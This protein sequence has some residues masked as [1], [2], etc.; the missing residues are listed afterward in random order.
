MT[1]LRP[2]FSLL[3]LIILIIAAYLVWSWYQ[4]HL[5]Q[6]PDGSFELRRDDWRLWL[7][8]LLMFWSFLGR[9]AVLPLLARTSAG[10]LAAEDQGGDFVPGASGEMLYVRSFGPADAPAI[11]LTHGWSLDQSVWQYAVRDLSQNYR[12]IV[13]DLPG[14]GKSTAKEVS[15][16]CM[17]D[18]LHAVMAY[19]ARPALLVGHSIG[20][21]TIQTLLRNHPELQA[22]IPGIALVNTTYTNP[23]RT[24]VLSWLFV[25]L[26]WPL[27]E[28]MLW[29]QIGLKPMAWLMSWQSYLSGW[30]HLTARLAFGPLVTRDQLDHTA[31]LMTKNSPSVMA[32]GDLAMF[33]WDA[34]SALPQVAVPVLIIAGEKDIVTLPEASRRMADTIP[35]ARLEIVPEANHM[36]V[37]ETAGVY[38]RMIAEFAS[39]VLRSEPRTARQHDDV[40]APEIYPRGNDI[41]KS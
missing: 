40:T 35:G 10:S 28:P 1:A 6:R 24:I 3:S 16:D 23:L 30:T 26:R 12:V 2:I 7:G 22:R 33:R 20:G 17:A 15:L 34:T 36:G 21:M 13:W 5:I 4:G 32:R 39:S 29:I 31:Y 25:L 27:I 38:N 8:I 14:L 9:S 41:M 19:V 37:L 11:L 18:N